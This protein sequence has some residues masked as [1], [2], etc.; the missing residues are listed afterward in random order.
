MGISFLYEFQRKLH[1]SFYVPINFSTVRERSHSATSSGREVA[2][3]ETGRYRENA[4]F[5]WVWHV[6]GDEK[7]AV[8]KRRRKS[9][10]IISG[11]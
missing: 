7:L 6:V 8:G 11:P 5:L 9:V 10:R 1:Y 3:G 2:H 4:V